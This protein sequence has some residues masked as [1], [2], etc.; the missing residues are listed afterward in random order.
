MVPASGANF[1][2]ESLQVEGYPNMISTAFLEPMEPF[3]RLIYKFLP[4]HNDDSTPLKLSEP[5]VLS[6]LAKLIPRR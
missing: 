4:S 1:L 2:I 5:A 6:A 3:Q